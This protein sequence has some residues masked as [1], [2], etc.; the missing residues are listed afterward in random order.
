MIKLTVT[1]VV[2]ADVDGWAQARGISAAA[3]LMEIRGYLRDQANG[4]V[5]GQ[6]HLVLAQPAAV[7]LDL[8]LDGVTLD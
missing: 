3:A 8:G 7:T 6:T 4:L 2:D 1:T 5:A